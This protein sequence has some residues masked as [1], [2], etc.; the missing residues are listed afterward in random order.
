VNVN[1]G[2]ASGPVRIV[3][4]DGMGELHANGPLTISAAASIIQAAIRLRWEHCPIIKRILPKWLL[5][6]YSTFRAEWTKS[7]LDNPQ[8]KDLSFW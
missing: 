7:E 8:A 3:K 6:Q 2:V 1:V 4:C 5:V